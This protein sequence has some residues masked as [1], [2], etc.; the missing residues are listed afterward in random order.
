MAG[1]SVVDG[2]VLDETRERDLKRNAAVYSASRRTT[3]RA[4]VV[5]RVALQAHQANILWEAT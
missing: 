2:A 5:R 3:A 1:R 4:V